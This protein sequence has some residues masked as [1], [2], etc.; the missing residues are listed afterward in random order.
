MIRRLLLVIGLVALLP[1]SLFAQTPLASILPSLLEGGVTA[2]LPTQT[3]IPGVPHNAHF[4]AAL[5]QDA[6]PFAIN[7]LLAEQLVPRL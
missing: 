4:V 3:G 2:T 7:K 1:S 6:A 5:G